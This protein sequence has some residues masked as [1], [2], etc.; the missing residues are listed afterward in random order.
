MKTYVYK[1]IRV[2]ATVI[3][4]APAVGLA[5]NLQ[6]SNVSIVNPSAGQAD[7]QFTLSWDNSWHE[8]W[9][10][11]GG[12][13]SVTNWDA[14][15]IFAKY[16]QN[17]GL[18]KHVHFTATGH[19]ATGG[20]VIEVPHDGDGARPGAFVRRNAT[21]TGT[22]TCTDMKLHVDIAAAGLPSADD[23]DI[24]VMGIEMVYIPTGAFHLGSGGSEQQH[25][26]TAADT[27]TTYLVGSEAAITMGTET[28][29]L[30]ATGAITHGSLPV[31]FPKGY[32]AFYCMKYEITEGQYVD[33]LNLLDP[34]IAGSYF[35]AQ[36]NYRH[37]ITAAAGGGY[38]SAAPDRAC[39]YIGSLNRALTYLDWAGLRPMTEL[40]YEKVC[41]GQKQPWVNEFPW[42]NTTVTNITGFDGT[43]GSG[44][45]TAIPTNTNAHLSEGVSGPVRAG[46]FA[47]DTTTREQAGAGY[48]GVMEL[49][50]NLWEFVV[51]V[52]RSQGLPFSGAHGD[53]DEYTGYGNQ[54]P[55]SSYAYAR[56]GSSFYAGWQAARTSHRNDG[57]TT[58]ENAESGARGVRTAPNP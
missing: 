16:R 11:A 26:H 51:S 12:T 36:S 5:N 19:T 40:E 13:I 38:E 46:I 52:A 45:E 33:F 3:A 14:V 58:A 8:T 57:N 25:F 20:T 18:W 49:G 1:H 2:L 35:P 6:I 34:G 43:D 30:N 21:G 27:N 42:G 53:G 37:T 22:V 41:R 10:E 4:F 17:G 24:S 47:T 31:D 7:I 44:T 29:N 39:S 56:R 9:T 48:Y 54:W 28:G 15:W 50:G 23:I 32:K 55:D